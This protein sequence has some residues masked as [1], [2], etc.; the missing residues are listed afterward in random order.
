MTFWE[1]VAEV[2]EEFLDESEIIASSITVRVCEISV[3]LSLKTWEGVDGVACAE[4]GLV[5]GAVSTATDPLVES[6]GCLRG[7]GLRPGI[8]VLEGGASRTGDGCRSA[9]GGLTE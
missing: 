9:A 4:T 2:W 3:D 6:G 1:G 8:V 5:I 7:K